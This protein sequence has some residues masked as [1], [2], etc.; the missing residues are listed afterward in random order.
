MSQALP[1]NRRGW[2]Q[3]AAALAALGLGG[4]AAPAGYAPLVDADAD[5]PKGNFNIIEDL[6][7]RTFRYF[8]ETANPDNG[9]AFDRWPTS[10][11]C[12]IAAIGFALTA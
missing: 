9:L 7:Q 5:L 8:W 10:S 12:S 4:C 3:T 11:P 6:A 1:L 2:L